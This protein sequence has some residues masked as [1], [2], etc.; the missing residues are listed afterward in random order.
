MYPLLI[1]ISVMKNILKGNFNFTSEI[2]I[3]NV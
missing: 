2:F 1:I 3:G